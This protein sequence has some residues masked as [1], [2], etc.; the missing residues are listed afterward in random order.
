[1]AW[2]AL[3]KSDYL[4]W[5]IKKQ[6]RNTYLVKC[7][8]RHCLQNLC[9]H[10]PVWTAAFKGNWQTGHSHSSSIALTNSSSYPPRPSD[11]FAPA[12]A[13]ASSLAR[14]SRTDKMNSKYSCAVALR[15]STLSGATFRYASESYVNFTSSHVTCCLFLCYHVPLYFRGLPNFCVSRELISRIWI[16]GF[17]AG[18]KF[19][20][21][22][23]KFR[24]GISLT[25]LV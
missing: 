18:N 21:I 1:M 4:N 23:G 13:I 22:S 5:C 25:I 10:I 7:S 3:F 8:S 6:A 24:S 15:I 17:T 11:A 19:W 14:E 16:S 2:L 9:P 12:S 20:R